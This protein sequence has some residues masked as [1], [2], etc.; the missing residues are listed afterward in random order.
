MKF[1][2]VCVCGG[3]QS[4]CCCVVCEG[5]RMCWCGSHCCD[6]LL[7][8]GWPTYCFAPSAAFTFH[9]FSA[10]SSCWWAVPLVGYCNGIPSH[11]KTLLLARRSKA[12][13]KSCSFRCELSIEPAASCRQWSECHYTRLTQNMLIDMYMY[14][15]KNMHPKST[16]RPI[17]QAQPRT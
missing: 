4:C 3:D 16:R 8:R 12:A 15:T 13:S 9:I 1:D 5:C 17:S 14:T 11:E 10:V 7:S 2:V 6:G